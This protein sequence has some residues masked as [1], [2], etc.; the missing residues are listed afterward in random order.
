MN[1]PRKGQNAIFNRDKQLQ[2]FFDAVLRSMLQYVNFDVVKV[3][4]LASPGF[5]KD[6]FFK[7]AHDEASRR[8]YRE[9][10]E[11]KAKF[12]L[13]HSSSGHKH[14]LQE[15]LSSPGLQTR[16]QDTKAVHETR[17]LDTFFDTLNSDPDRAV[18]GPAHVF[19]ALSMSAIATLLITDELFRNA[20]VKQRKMYVA[21]VEE[22]QNSGGRV[23]IFSSL[24]VTGEQLS[25]MTGFAAMLRFPLPEI[26]EMDFDADVNDGNA[27]LDED[28]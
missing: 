19:Y 8:G 7:Y 3:I 28:G 13:A 1:I 4:L 15:A 10:L 5:V 6:S 14:A 26:D 2:K 25:S 17:A 18:Y 12:V 16:L 20:D 27:A 24:H 23:H 21:L 11:N 9:I 22:V